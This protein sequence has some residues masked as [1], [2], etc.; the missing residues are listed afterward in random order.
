[1]SEP[2]YDEIM[3]DKDLAFSEAVKAGVIPPQLDSLGKTAFDML[4]A[5]FSVA[6]NAVPKQSPDTTDDRPV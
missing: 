1:M 2:T 3:Q 5:I 6:H 4:W